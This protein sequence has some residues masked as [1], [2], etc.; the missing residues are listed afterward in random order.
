[1]AHNKVYGFCESGCKVEVDPTG[2]VK[3]IEEGGTGATN[4][5]TAREKLGAVSKTG[6][7]MTGPLTVPYLRVQ[8][9]SNNFPSIALHGAGNDNVS[10]ALCCDANDSV[11][12]VYVRSYHKDQDGKETRYPENYLFPAP[13]AG[14]GKEAFYSVLT[15]KT[16]VTIPQG[17]T[18]AT[19]AE[20]ARAKLGIT[21]AN[22]GA[23][24]AKHTHNASDISGGKIPIENGGTNATDAATARK[25]LGAV[26]KTGDAMTGQLAVPF[27]KVQNESNNFPS[28]ALHGMGNDNVSGALCCDANNT[29]RRMYVRS[30]NADQDGKATRYSENYLFPVPSSGLDGEKHYNV[31][32]TKS[33]VTIPQGGTGGGTP[34]EARENLG[35]AAKSH[36]HSAS[37]INSGTLPVERGG[38]NGTTKKT[39][40]KGIGLEIQCGVIEKVN[41]SDYQLTFPEP[42]SG[43][44]VV[45]AN[46][47]AQSSIRVRNITATGCEIT[48]GEDGNRN[49]QWQAIYISD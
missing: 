26:S 38:T 45:T 40:R 44:P 2:K 10:G 27:L 22:I 17:G 20:T 24:A 7:T 23:A 21:P 8:N 31:L 37:D 15:T 46:G 48:S 33:P 4:A 35:A 1:M 39:A 9:E 34:E 18:G 12:R 14:M 47:S 5:K 3:P 16:P 6:D 36:N 32:T 25:N 49:V 28:I 43:I 30:Y 11:R 42:F 41:T 13:N 19:D 29:V